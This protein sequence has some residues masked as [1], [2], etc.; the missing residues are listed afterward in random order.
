MTERIKIKL[1][2][3]RSKEYRKN[4]RDGTDMRELRAAGSVREFV[5]NFEY[6]TGFA[7]P[8]IHEGDDFGFCI[9]TSR[10]IPSPNGNITPN[11]YR[12]ATDGF[13]KTREN[14]KK[15]M[16][17]TSDKEKLEYGKA[18]LRTLD[19]CERV[20]AEHRTLAKERGCERLY[21]ALCKIPERPAESFYEA[22]VFV[23]M[24]I[25][26]LRVGFGSHL[27]FGRFDKYMYPFYLN[28]KAR[29]VSDEEIYE[30]LLEFF[31]SVNYDS[32]IYQGVQQGDNGQSM[33]LGGVNERGES[34]YNELS[35]MCLN[36]SLELDLIDPK[37]NLRV[38]KDTPMELY[39]LGTELTR[40]GLG[41]PQYCNDDV[42]IPGLISLGYEPS[43]AA[44]YVVAACWE[45]IIP[46][47]SADI[48]NRGTFDFPG[49]VNSVVMSE[50]ISC[51]SFDELMMR[52]KNGIARGCEAVREKKNGF[53]TSPNPIMSIMT[54]GC[55]EN[56][57]DLWVGAKYRNYGCHGAGIANAADALAAI[58]QN[59]FEKKTLS[60]EALV[61]ALEKNF[62]GEEEL[63][64][65]L[66][67]SPK[68][69]DNDDYADEIAADIMLA[70]SENMNLYDNGV[71]GIWRAGTGSAMEYIWKG[72][73]C[74]ATADGRRA[75]EPYSSSFSPSLDVKNNGLL[76]VIQ[77]FTKFDMKKIINGGP[78]TVEIH[79]STLRGDVGIEKVAM[80]VRTFIALGGHQLQLNSVNRERLL[81]AQAHPERY[82]GLIVRVWGWSGYF[83][84]LDIKY[85]NHII[86]RV[87]HTL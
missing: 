38:N 66:R 1:D 13:D 44:N 28:D 63:R 81:E 57:T 17:E 19:I 49:V 73:I 4:R 15:A 32:D 59:V 27:G 62:E 54:D 56:L 71:G 37:I 48:P 3:L 51:P 87:E 34:E 69:G 2:A 42:V 46:H 24:M 55:I 33:V 10:I 31:I 20:A 26:F 25:Y 74:P 12:L 6:I 16:S 58:K 85:Q 40:R 9:S 64:S 53:K 60:A 50:L 67:S 79:D 43:D 77:S 36:A 45:F 8:I 39:K 75:G 11:Y 70:F 7:A 86:R 21:N 29:G 84:E 23:R 65:L 83:S 52:V 18:M 82:P 61:C 41:F 30:T 72:D 47:C 22:L 35:E 76:S 14:I 5:D 68:M 80:L 78:L